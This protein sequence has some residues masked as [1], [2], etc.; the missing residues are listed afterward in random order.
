M[1]KILES[2]TTLFD[3][4]KDWIEKLTNLEASEEPETIKEFQIKIHNDIIKDIN[5]SIVERLQTAL[6]IQSEI[7]I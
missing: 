7:V 1:K 5:K 3:I 6:E 2:I 4:R